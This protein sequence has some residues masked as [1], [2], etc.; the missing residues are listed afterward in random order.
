M[1]TKIQKANAKINIY[2]QVLN[3]NKDNSVET[4][5]QILKNLSLTKSNI[6][7]LKFIFHE[8][9]GNI[10]DHSE[11]NNAYII[12]KSYF[13]YSEF[14]FIDDGISIPISLKNNGYAFKNDS[15]AIMNAINGLSTKN[16]HGYIERGTGLNNTTNIVTWG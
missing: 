3:K 14:S 10:Y 7:V 15:Q 5:N 9:I 12:G 8:L 2:L 11:F 6:S 4:T 16:E 13:E 1:L